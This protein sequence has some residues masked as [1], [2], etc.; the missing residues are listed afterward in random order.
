MEKQTH[1]I[2]ARPWK[3]FLVVGLL[4]ALTLLL[5]RFTSAAPH[6]QYTYNNGR[7]GFGFTG[8][9]SG[10][11]GNYNT[12]MLNAGWYWDWTAKGASQAPPLEYM[13][14]IHL[15]PVKENS[16]QI[17]YT[18]SPTGTT[19]RNLLIA[20]PGA[21]WMIGNEPDCTAMDNMV[22]E[23]YARAYHD[24]YTFI[25]S[26]D[27]TAQVAAGN[28]VQPTAMRF[29][30][31]DRILQTYQAEYG[32]PLPAD[33]WVT[34]AYILCEKCYPFKAPG[35]PF[36]WGACWVPDWPSY[37]AALPYATFYSVYDHWNIEVF[38]ERLID[39]RQWMY[40]N[41]YRNQPLLIAEYGI[42]FYDGLVYSG[43]EYQTLSQDF[44]YA[45]FD[46]MR[47]ARDPQI[48]F[49]LDDDRLIQRWAW[50]SLDHD[51]WYYG[52]NLFDP[53]SRQPTAFGI[54]YGN[55]TAQI[56]PTVDLNLFDL[57][58][59]HG[60]ASPY[61]LKYTATFTLAN[62]GDVMADALSA[63]V[64]DQQN[65]AVHLAQA[66]QAALSCCGN[67]RQI[68]LTWQKHSPALQELCVQAPAAQSSSAPLC[69]TTGADLHI[70]K[71]WA[72]THVTPE[73][74]TPVSATLY[75]SV[76]NT[77]DLGSE[78]PIIVTFSA[79]HPQMSGAVVIG[80]AVAAPAACC[81]GA[82]SVALPWS[83]YERG[84]II[85]V[86]ARTSYQTTDPATVT[87]KSQL[88]ITQAWAPVVHSPAG[89]SVTAT[90][91]ARAVN[92]GVVDTLSP[93]TV[94]FYVPG[95]TTAPISDTVLMPP[96]PCCEAYT[97]T[98]VFWPEL[99]DAGLFHFCAVAMTPEEISA[100]ACG[101]FFVNP[102]QIYFPVLL[103]R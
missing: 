90:L 5:V 31:L 18:A 97:D 100:P 13:Q 92:V 55:Y 54:S 68:T 83:D 59:D 51:G 82:T 103:R 4:A 85:T 52:G 89:E 26:V 15:K 78:E 28:I 8:T 34:H 40:D 20:N 21:T 88:V 1:I 19:L 27:P 75:A 2:V 53:Q 41:G 47:S 22:S 9:N 6:A 24:M 62:A 86:T 71:I 91:Y 38:K 99:P 33:L 16:V 98:A 43:E 44:M 80:E 10:V 60:T 87:L 94:S 3:K 25:K 14:V 48:G 29:M 50:Y 67:H 64:Y 46:W 7:F 37:N 63:Y 35:E 96:L 58:F 66:P 65:P 17:G 56:S 76:I 61:P 12:P 23:W 95:S 79:Q 81:N 70:G 84:S 39:L 57:T 30:Y 93:I 74:T 32:E 36:A 49:A 77:G 45:G 73:G 102:K 42:L 101:R 11:P 72:Q 69:R